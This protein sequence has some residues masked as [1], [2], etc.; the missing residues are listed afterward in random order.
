MITIAHATATS[1]ASPAAFFARWIDHETWSQWD[2]D[3]DWAR[4]DGPVVRGATGTLKPVSG[5]K[6]RFTI[7]ELTPDAEYTDRTKLLGATLYFQHLVEATDAGAALAVTVTLD[8]PL[9]GLWARIL[10]ADFAT[11]APACLE[12]LVELVE[13]AA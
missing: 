8:G 3:T 1:T 7:H 11:A 6:T 5:P 13:S 9:A 10:G 4:V 2:T 12:R